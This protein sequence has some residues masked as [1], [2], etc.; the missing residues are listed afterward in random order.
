[1]K[2]NEVHAAEQNMTN[3]QRLSMQAVV[4]VDKLYQNK[5]YACTRITVIIVQS[6]TYKMGWAMRRKRLVAQLT[7]KLHVQVCTAARKRAEVIQLNKIWQVTRDYQ[8]R[9][10]VSVDKLYQNKI[11]MH[12]KNQMW[13]KETTICSLNWNITK[14]LNKCTNMKFKYNN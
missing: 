7:R 4:S 10:E 2:R 12:L 5:K 3:N 8:R 11:K 14:K 1:M 6:I 13:Q 9:Q